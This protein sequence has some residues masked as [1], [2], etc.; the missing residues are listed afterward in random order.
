MIL[1]IFLIHDFQ[2]KKTFFLMLV[3]LIISYIASYSYVKTAGI[4]KF[5]TNTIIMIAVLQLKLHVFHS[6]FDPFGESM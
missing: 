6:S 4:Y 1:Y 3:L 5:A 2:S